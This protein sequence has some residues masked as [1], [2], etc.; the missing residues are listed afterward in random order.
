[1]SNSGEPPILDRI[2]MEISTVQSSKHDE[3]ELELEEGEEQTP[4]HNSAQDNRI[5]RMEQNFNN[6]QEV[7][8]RLIAKAESENQRCD[9]APA[10]RESPFY[11]TGRRMVN[12]ARQTSREIFAGILDRVS[13][14]RNGRIAS[15]EI[16]IVKSEPCATYDNPDSL[17]I[18]Y[19]VG[20]FYDNTTLLTIAV[21]EEILQLKLY[22]IKKIESKQIA[23]CQLARYTLLLKERR[24]IEFIAYCSINFT[25]FHER[26]RQQ[27]F[28]PITQVQNI[29]GREQKAVCIHHL[30]PIATIDDG[31]NR[32]RSRR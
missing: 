28:E 29:G 5:E 10:S 2:D 17:H 1:M 11:N 31:D 23:N 25:T 8:N 3:L 7:L 9:P 30:V 16:V 6:L 27:L 15:G 12:R 32:K 26:G 19:Q 18:V 13:Q 24:T 14:I 21:T 22:I 4:I 20:I